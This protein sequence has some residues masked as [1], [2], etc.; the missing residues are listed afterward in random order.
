MAV[1]DKYIV[2]FTQLLNSDEFN[3]DEYIK[4]SIFKRRLLNYLNVTGHQYGLKKIMSIFMKRDTNEVDMVKLILSD[5]GI[6]EREELQENVVYSPAG[7]LPYER[8]E[9]LN[10]I[11]DNMSNNKDAVIFDFGIYL[12]EVN[13]IFKNNKVDVRNFLRSEE[14][15]IN[16]PLLTNSIVYGIKSVYGRGIY[17]KN[18]PKILKAISLGYSG[19][20]IT[21]N[22][23]LIES[24][25]RN[26][27]L[28]FI[29]RIIHIYD[30]NKPNDNLDEVINRVIN[31]EKFYFTEKFVPIL[32]DFH[33]RYND[34]NSLDRLVVK[35]VEHKLSLKKHG[36]DSKKIGELLR[37]YGKLDKYKEKSSVIVA[38]LSEYGELKLNK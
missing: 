31:S 16:V 2:Q 37:F 38:V 4:S 10:D 18:S 21:S 13:G 20:E 34:I 1:D 36:I 33:R 23:L 24:Y 17:T 11:E 15:L 26:Y 8:E 27:D 19:K 22:D 5:I 12:N 6:L 3:F 35:C 25:G 9:L 7:K 30:Y 32:L 29:N 14:L 28:N